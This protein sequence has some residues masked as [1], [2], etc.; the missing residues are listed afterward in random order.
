MGN[1]G[2]YNK[3]LWER[4]LVTHSECELSHNCSNLVMVEAFP[5]SSQKV[6]FSSNWDHLRDIDP[7]AKFLGIFHPYLTHIKIFDRLNNHKRF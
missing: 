4:I 7:Y 6:F 1:P 2:P 3:G 5:K